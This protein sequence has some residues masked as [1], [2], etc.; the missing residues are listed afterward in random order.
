[1]RRSSD[2]GDQALVCDWVFIGCSVAEMLRARMLRSRGRGVRK[3]TDCG[4]GLSLMWEVDDAEQV[5]FVCL[6]SMSC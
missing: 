6:F 2:L 4:Q 3:V 5:R 1:M